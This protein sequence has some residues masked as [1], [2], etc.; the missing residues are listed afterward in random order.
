MRYDAVNRVF[1]SRIDINDNDT[2]FFAGERGYIWGYGTES[3]E[4]FL[5][6]SPNWNWPTGSSTGFPLEWTTLTY[7]RIIVGVF[8]TRMTEPYLRTENV[9]NQPLPSLT[10]TAWQATVFTP[11][12][13]ANSDI[14]SWSADPDLDGHSNLVEYA[15]DGDPFTI[16]QRLGLKATI[17]ADSGQPTYLDIQLNRSRTRLALTQIELS[18]DLTQW[19]D[20]GDAVQEDRLAIQRV[21]LPWETIHHQFVRIRVTEH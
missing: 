17:R 19:D 9:G 2:P 7:T 15:L 10:K 12:Q 21:R 4:W 16:E 20:A 1:T 6:S 14:S 13:L 11:G 18:T 8:P 3:N 5:M